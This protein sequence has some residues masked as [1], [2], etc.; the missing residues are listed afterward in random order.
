MN[1]QTIS[2]MTLAKQRIRQDQK[3]WKYI[4]DTNTASV[5]DLKR[6]AIADGKKTYTYGLMF[7]EWERY[8]SVFSALGMTG[9]NRS[10]VGLLG[11]TSA[12]AIFAFY[13]LNMVGAEV[14]LI[15]S[16]SAFMPGKIT[17]TIRSERLTDF[18]VT[19]EFAQ[20]DVI[21]ELFLR[22]KSL[23]LKNIILLHVP[24]NG[25]TVNPMLTARK[26]R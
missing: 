18:I 11:S 22:K 15:P 3:L 1:G 21:G 17:Q 8:A 5:I 6:T 2:K 10:R 19:D 7:R 23:G 13:G 9:E 24:A 12:K 4:R 26:N 16:Y 14:S 20:A 25:V